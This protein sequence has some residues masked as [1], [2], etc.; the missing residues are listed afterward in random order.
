MDLTV[1]LLAR[2]EEGPL[3]RVLP[4]LRTMLRTMPVEV[5]VLVVDGRSED[6]TVAVS[7]DLGARVVVQK[8]PGYGAAFREGVHAAV[9]THIVNLDADG[10]HDPRDVP[11]LYAHRHEADVVIGSRYCPK[12]RHHG[13]W[14]RHVLSRVLNLIFQH[15]LAI[16]IRDISSGLRLYRAAALRR[17]PMT[18]SDFDILEEV[19][20]HLWGRGARILEIPIHFRPRHSGVSK[21]RLLHLGW[22][23]LRALRS[24]RR[25]RRSS[26]RSRRIS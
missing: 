4:E 22:R 3:R 19:L 6:A 12:G 1:M 11:E 5:E 24:L 14:F 25:I 23:Y 8:E 9:G 2:N 20:V 10:S 26:L 16:P 21:S 18:G 7:R 17:V 13:Q 15:I